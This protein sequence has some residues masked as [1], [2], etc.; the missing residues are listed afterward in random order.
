MSCRIQSCWVRVC[1]WL[2]CHSFVYQVTSY[3]KFLYWLVNQC[4][5]LKSRGYVMMV[6]HSPISLLWHGFCLQAC[7]LLC[8]GHGPGGHCGAGHSDW[9]WKHQALSACRD[10]ERLYTQVAAPVRL[11]RQTF[12]RLALWPVRLPDLLQWCRGGSVADSS[13]RV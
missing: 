9:L 8:G 7:V 6:F 4:N 12:T 2:Y 5:T 3:W 1:G 11:Y 13:H 10:P